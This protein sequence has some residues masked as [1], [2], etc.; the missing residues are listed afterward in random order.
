M[1][2]ILKITITALFITYYSSSI[3]QV[4]INEDG[5]SPDASAMLDISSTDKGL[6]IPRMDSTSRKNISN[7]TTGLLVFD[8]DNNSFWYY[9]SN[10]IDIGKSSLVQD[11]DGD[12][13]IQ[14]EESSDEDI[15]RF[16]TDGTEFMRLDNGRIEI[17]N[18]GESVFIGN[19][20]GDNDDYSNNNN[21][22]IGDESG[23]YNTT[24]LLNT[25]VGASSG[26]SNTTGRINT[27]VGAS[28]GL[29]NTT[30]EFNVF[31]GVFSGVFNQDGDKNIC[32]GYQAGFTNVSGD[33]N[34]FL[35]YQAGYN[36]T[37][38][39]K[40]YIENSN[41]DS[42]LIYGEFDNDRVVINGNSSDN[43]NNRTL[44]INGSIGA[45]SAFN[46]DSDRRLK[47]NIQTISNALDK[48]L[49]MRGVTYQWKDGREAGDRMGFIA[50]EVEPILPE[51]VDNANDH[52][53]MQYAP[54]TAVLVEA[55]KEQQIQIEKLTNKNE[56]QQSENKVLKQRLEELEA[57][58]TEINKMKAMLEQIQVQ[59]K[60]N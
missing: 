6:L 11:A 40:L 12:T 9:S 8:T 4:A 15:I 35:G 18:T 57:Q 46:N 1:R 54:I 28:S 25:F 24:G 3:A 26:T 60:S 36:E 5:S 43:S 32:I 50:Q 33:D 41:S 58:V 13:K 2:Y 52:Y 7:P 59:L 48:V 22:F 16:D 21:V 27:F 53:T 30:G 51:V 10:W 29:S 56:Q 34:M 17:L 20:A 23:R 39:N 38:S 19:Q 49:E 47:T 45:T 42:P 44:F 14:V 31:V 37:G 55:V